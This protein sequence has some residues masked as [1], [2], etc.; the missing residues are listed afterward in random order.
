MFRRKLKTTAPLLVP[1]LLASIT[2]LAAPPRGRVIGP[3]TSQTLG[4]LNGRGGPPGLRALA[5]APLAAA[6]ACSVYFDAT[7]QLNFNPPAPNTP[8]TPGISSANFIAGGPAFAHG[9]KS[10]SALTTG[11]ALAADAG[12]NG[13]SLQQPNAGVPQNRIRGIAYFATDT[14]CTQ[15]SFSTTLQSSPAGTTAP[16]P[17]GTV[18]AQLSA[19]TT[20][21]AGY[22]PA[23]S[24]QGTYIC[25]GVRR[26]WIPCEVWRVDVTFAFLTN[27]FLASGAGSYTLTINRVT[28]SSP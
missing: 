18:L 17:A 15:G 23:Y 7:G 21:T 24:D 10:T 4:R 27:S 19:G 5:A 9:T 11:L 25:S 1:L 2:T 3:A 22:T 8:L 12:I 26:G 20:M 6:P 16:A 13:V 28:L 14:G